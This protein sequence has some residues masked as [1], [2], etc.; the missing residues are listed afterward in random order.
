[1]YISE[2]DDSAVSRAAALGAWDDSTNTS[3]LGTLWFASANTGGQATFTVTGPI[4][5][6]GTYR[7]IPVA[8]VTGGI[9]VNDSVRF[10]AFSR[11]GNLGN[12]GPTGPTGPAGATGPTGPAGATGPTGPTGLTGPTGPAGETS[13]YVKQVSGQ[14]YQALLGVGTESATTT[15]T[16]DV[17]YYSPFYVSNTSVTFDQIS[18]RAGSNFSGF[19][20]VRL[21]IYADNNG[22]PGNLILDA[23][24]VSVVNAGTVY[25]A[26]ISQSLNQGMYWLAANSQTAATTNT[27]YFTTGGLTLHG[28]G[29]SSALNATPTSGWQQTGVTGAFAN[30]GTTTRA[31]AMRMS[32][33]VA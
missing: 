20:S 3:H 9:P 32:M 10:I 8:Y 33:R 30:A 31:S 4:V 6:E 2:T 15:A 24:T 19:A 28:I 11:T 16:E 23:S 26:T 12:T 22:K 7:T 1:M 5:D 13:T 27:Y 17:T 21:G 18:I 25:S 14:T 29:M